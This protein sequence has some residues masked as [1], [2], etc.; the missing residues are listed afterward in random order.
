MSG[1]LGT[2]ERE[3]KTSRKGRGGRGREQRGREGGESTITCSSDE[4]LTLEDK[5]MEGK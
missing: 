3:R 2:G 4:N 5:R 1:M